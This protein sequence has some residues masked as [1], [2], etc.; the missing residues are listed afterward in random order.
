LLFKS[1][2]E[3][4]GKKKNNNTLLAISGECKR[5]RLLLEISFLNKKDKKKLPKDIRPI[6]R[7]IPMTRENIGE[8]KKVS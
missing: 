6:K 7:R 1:P 8:Y 4:N 2:K 3:A 5:K